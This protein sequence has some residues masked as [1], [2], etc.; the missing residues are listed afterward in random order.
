MMSK[1]NTYSFMPTLRGLKNSSSSRFDMESNKI[2]SAII[3]VNDCVVTTMY[4][5]TIT[6]AKAWQMK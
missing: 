4:I 1:R 5:Y 3:F 6:Q 2:P